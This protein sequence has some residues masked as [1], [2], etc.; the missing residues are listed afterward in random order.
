VPTARAD[1]SIVAASCG[2]PAFYE[3]QYPDG[4]TQLAEAVAFL[5]Q[6]RGSVA[7]VTIDIG[8]NDLLDPNGIGPLLTELA[9]QKVVGS[10]PI[11]RS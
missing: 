6:H 7:F 10:S 4:G 11:I 2:P 3:H 1:D 5:E 8:A 9:M